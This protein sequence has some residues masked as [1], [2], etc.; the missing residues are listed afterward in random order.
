MSTLT[1]WRVVIAR[2]RELAAELTGADLAAITKR[3]D[4]VD[5]LGMDAKQS[6]QLRRSL[7]DEFEIEI[8]KADAKQLTTVGDLIRY[9]EARA[10]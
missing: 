1:D 10:R 6:A 8:P 2:V 5:D 4:L 7:Q 9:V 3:T